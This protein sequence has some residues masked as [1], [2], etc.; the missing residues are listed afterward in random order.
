M[1]KILKNDNA[2]EENII[3][4][5]TDNMAETDNE[6]ADDMSDILSDIEIIET[7]NHNIDNNLSS[8]NE[9]SES[10]KGK[11]RHKKPLIITVAVVCIL[12]LAATFSW[13]LYTKD[14]HADKKDIKIMTPYFLYLLNPDDKNSLQFS[15]GNIH[16]GEVKQ[17]VFCVSNKKPDDVSDGSIDIA[18]ESNFN[19]DLEFI[20]TE[21]LL[22]NYNIYE[23]KKSSY[24]D[25][26]DIPED[27]IVV[28]GVDNVYWQKMIKDGET[29]AA[30]L[31]YTRDE[32]ATRLNELFGNDGT[33]IFNKGKYFLYQ[34]DTNGN[35]L[36]LEYKNTDGVSQYEYDY[37]LLEISWQ[38][39]VD[40]SKYTK[41]TD[42]VY[43]VVNAKQPKP[44]EK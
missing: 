27:G 11:K 25:E 21:N 3:D 1:K 7:E 18:R 34:N 6:N 43:V 2:K 38:D 36:A 15:V 12:A 40:F 29:S 4:K 23:L 35:P 41:E 8:D 13:Y 17:I 30:P 26:A 31:S 32:T 5:E 28:D 14:N 37:Y 42:L 22:V 24:S 9:K 44:V 19:Y 20:Y 33:G 39:G 10:S 16:P